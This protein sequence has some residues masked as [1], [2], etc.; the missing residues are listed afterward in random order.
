MSF[1]NNVFLL[2]KEGQDLSVAERF[3]LNTQIDIFTQDYLQATGEVPES[4]PTAFYLIADR[5]EDYGFKLPRVERW[6]KEDRAAI[7]ETCIEK[8]CLP[9]RER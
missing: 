7:L 6:R 9:K 8:N 3:L 5:L 2:L 4:N 1:K